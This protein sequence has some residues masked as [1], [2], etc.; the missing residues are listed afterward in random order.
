MSLGSDLAVSDLQT[1]ITEFWHLT[2]SVLF[3]GVGK[4]KDKLSFFP[5][6][7]SLASQGMHSAEGLAGTSR[8]RASLCLCLSKV[9]LGEQWLK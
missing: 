3:S 4:G 2:G 6:S 9:V 7:F 5:S 1:K 8:S